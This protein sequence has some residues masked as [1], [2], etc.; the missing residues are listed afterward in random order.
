MRNVQQAMGL[1]LTNRIITRA[2]NSI[3][4]DLPAHPP[5]RVGPYFWGSA[6]FGAGDE[7]KEK[8]PTLNHEA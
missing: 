7:N 2:I 6:A 1:E 3:A 4:A 5:S 8:K